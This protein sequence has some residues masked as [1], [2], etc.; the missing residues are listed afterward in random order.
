MTSNKIFLLFDTN[1][2]EC[3]FDKDCLFLC[4]PK[5][6]NLFY[7]IEN[8][9]KSNHLENNISL[10][11]SEISLLELKKH[12]LDCYK[13]KT[14]SLDASME[15][16]KKVFGDL[17]EINVN[18][19]ICQNI[20]EYSKH[21][22][23]Y[24]ENVVKER[25]NYLQIVQYPKNKETIVKLVNKAMKTQAPFSEAKMQGKTYT[26]AG[27]KDALIYETLEQFIGDNFGILVSNDND[28]KT[29]FDKGLSPENIII[30]NDKNQ[31]IHSIYSH[32]E[33]EKSSE[34]AEF[35]FVRDF[36]VDD[37]VIETLLN[38]V[39]FN[40]DSNYNFI[41]VLKFSLDNENNQICAEFESYINGDKYIFEIIYEP[42]AREIIE[43]ISF[44]GENE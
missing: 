43:V 14:D 1:M 19:N 16:Y 28:F 36:T 34:Q 27:F 4:Q 31:I 38:E 9:I 40:Q 26:D 20:N 2:L 17:F 29:F 33:V 12:L 5:F 11:I 6:S 3:R 35:C 32:L 39:G 7:E 24:F 30:Q 10:L 21:I 44:R 22:D 13:S 15:N 23:E 42:N 41:R 37:Y 18:K 25:E 8:F